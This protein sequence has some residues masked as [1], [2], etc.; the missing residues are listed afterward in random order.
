MSGCLRFCMS[1]R[2][3]YV[4]VLRAGPNVKMDKSI[5]PMVSTCGGADFGFGAEGEIW[6]GA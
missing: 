5:E 3:D 6:C 1:Y 4:H 2:E